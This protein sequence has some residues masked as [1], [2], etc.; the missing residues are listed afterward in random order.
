MTDL[1]LFTDR[2]LL[3]VGERP[4]EGDLQLS[5]A[6]DAVPAVLGYKTDGSSIHA[7]WPASTAAPMQL[8]RRL[9][10]TA[11]AAD[12]APLSLLLLEL[13]IRLTQRTGTKTE[14]PEY[15]TTN[16]AWQGCKEDEG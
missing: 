7:S 1:Y 3:K 16:D 14:G 15:E 9:L 5:R 10:D 12:A 8:L 6:R 13:L 4:F 11:L 2:E